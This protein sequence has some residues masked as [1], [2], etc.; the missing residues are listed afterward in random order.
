M[1]LSKRLQAIADLVSEGLTV[2]DIGTDHALLPVYLVEQGKNP[3]AIAMDVKEGPLSRARQ[4]IAAAA[5]E[6]KIETRLSDGFAALHPGEAGSAVIAGMGGDL[7]I[8]ILKEGADVVRTL[9]EVVCSPQS[10]IARVRAYAREQGFSID[11]EDMVLE[12]GK[13]YQMFRLRPGQAGSLSEEEPGKTGLLTEGMQDVWDHYGKILLQS[14]HPVLTGYLRWERRVKENILLQL[15]ASKESS[16]GST[17]E[18]RD[19]VIADLKRNE[20]AQRFLNEMIGR[21]GFR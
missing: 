14:G 10:H 18:R 8:R 20:R 6:E 4:T 16:I 21:S 19:E 7:M 3:A 2:A 17:Q 11:A 12:D 15:A 13:Y 5:L 1:I 9:D